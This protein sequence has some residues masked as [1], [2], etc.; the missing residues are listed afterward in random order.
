MCIAQSRY[1]ITCIIFAA[2]RDECPRNL[3]ADSS[4]RYAAKVRDMDLPFAA[5]ILAV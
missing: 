3:A 4:R 2:Y 5:K 1:I